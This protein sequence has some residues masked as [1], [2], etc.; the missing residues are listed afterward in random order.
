M[1]TILSCGHQAT[2]LNKGI[3][4]SIAAYDR[5]GDPVVKHAVL[6]QQCYDGEFRRGNVLFSD[7]DVL[8]WLEGC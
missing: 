1:T 7:E 8:M 4:A 2:S 3:E 6:C 5:Q